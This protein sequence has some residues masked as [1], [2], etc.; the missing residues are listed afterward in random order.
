MAKLDPEA[1]YLALEKLKKQLIELV[2][3]QP[4]GLTDEELDHCWTEAKDYWRIYR[5]DYLPG[6][7]D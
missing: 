4:K 2:G 1:R 6:R 3:K 5:F 7:P